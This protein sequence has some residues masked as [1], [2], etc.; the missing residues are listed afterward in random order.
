MMLPRLARQVRIARRFA[1]ARVTGGRLPLSVAFMLTHRCNFRCAHCQI[2]GTCTDEMSAGEFCGA[3][4]ELA[5]AGMTRASFS[6]GE[7]LLRSDTAQ[8]VAH[9]KSLGLFTSLNSNGWLAQE[10]L[11]ELAG[12]LDMVVF[13][14]DGSAE[15]HDASR[16]QPG[17]HARVLAAICKARSLGIAV[18]TITLVQPDCLSVIDD[19]LQIA[20]DLGF[21]PYFQPIQE[22]CFERRAGIRT[23]PDDGWLRDL[24]DRL[25]RARRDGLPVGNSSAWLKLLASGK[26]QGGCAGCAAGRFT[27]TVLPDGTLVPCHMTLGDRAWPNGRR[28]GFAKAFDE[29]PKPLPT[30]GCTI[31]PNR[32]TTLLLSLKP[33]SVLAALR[34][35][36]PPPG[37]GG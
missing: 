7:A 26:S 31:S 30:G 23:G 29:M 36:R 16:S 10:R 21:W 27:A 4:N 25:L 34:H 19:V 6:G 5:A 3:I 35:L 33:T 32:E 18:A 14:L 8:I 20:G 12:S 15:A 11:G 2:P 13:S 24:A 1:V 28:L 17:S 37:R 9:A 22:N